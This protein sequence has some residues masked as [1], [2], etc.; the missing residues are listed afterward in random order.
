MTRAVHGV[1]KAMKPLRSLVIASV[2][3]LVAFAQASTL[4][5]QA[6]GPLVHVVRPGETLASIAE[7]YYGD[8]RREGVIVAE[9]GLGSEGGSSIV[10]GLRLTIPSVR[11]HQV[12]EGDTWP[13][14]AERFY[15][16]VRRAFALIEANGQNAGK[17]PDFGAEI[18]VP[19]P[20]RVVVVT[21]HDA[22]RQIGKDFL[23]N[24]T[25]AI[26]TIRRFNMMKNSRTTRGEILLVPLAD[27]RLSKEGQRLAQDQ[28]VSEGRV[29]ELR[30][31]QL[32]TDAELPRL[33]E[34]V[35]RGRYVEAV[36][37]AN[38][39]LGQGEL[40]GNQMVTTQ[41]ELGTALIALEREDLALEAFKVMLE[42][43]PD[44]D[45]G[46]GATSPKVLRV[47]EEARKQLARAASPTGEKPAGEKPA[48]EKPAS[49]KPAPAS[50]T[51]D[52]AKRR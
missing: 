20:L 11:F 12:G 46:I 22:L 16:D 35:Q 2:C 42:K 1:W 32:A 21:Q 48:S 17:L 23:G 44:V 37:M 14:L 30:E 26:A 28:G 50:K 4:H 27:L 18:L 29:G 52:K 41:R 43:Q 38:R 49:E 15:G 36:S 34:H 13:S 8:P 25:T 40:T 7:L 10:V 47:L 6:M 31:R 5:A 9:N 19:H 33:R 24:K 45:L 39:L 3:A 51:G